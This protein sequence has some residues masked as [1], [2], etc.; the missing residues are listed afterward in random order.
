MANE[1]KHEEQAPL[2]S[3]NGSNSS[4]MNEMLDDAKKFSMTTYIGAGLALA[5]LIFCFI[6]TIVVRW[7]VMLPIAIA[8]LIISFSQKAK[9]KGTEKLVCTVVFVGLLAAVLLR[10]AIMAHKLAQLLDG[11]SEMA[12][13]FKGMES[14]FE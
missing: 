8:G 13:A 6:D 10:D 12:N 14:M 5:F 3:G 7:W 9:T 2:A 11:I 4:K 1:Q